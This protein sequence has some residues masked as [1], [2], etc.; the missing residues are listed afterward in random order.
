MVG[1]VLRPDHG[2]DHRP[3]AK[4]DL[5]GSRIAWETEDGQKRSAVEIEAEEVVASL[6]FATV[7]IT[8]STKAGATDEVHDQG[9]EVPAWDHRQHLGSLRGSHPGG[10]PFAC[11]SPFTPH[12][13]HRTGLLG[14][15][16]VSRWRVGLFTTRM[17]T[18]LISWMLVAP[19]QVALN[20]ILKDDGQGAWSGACARL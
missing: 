16:L 2:P 1:T 8:K 14:L 7:I 4:P 11:R 13:D 18:F 20:A 17:V 12:I 5:C 6:R 10:S 15:I 9:E 19:P 3:P